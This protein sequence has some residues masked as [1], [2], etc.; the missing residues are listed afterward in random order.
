MTQQSQTIRNV[1]V[2][3]GAKSGDGPE[4]AATAKAFGLALAESGRTL[5]FGGGQVGMMGHVANAA[6]AA[7]GDVIG[8]IPQ[9][10]ATAELLHTGVTKMHVVGGMHERKALMDQLAD[11]IVALP[12]GYGT[13]DE[14]FE[15]ITWSQLGVHRKP[16]ALLN[17]RGFFDPLVAMIDHSVEEGFISPGH[18][19][20]FFVASSVEDVLQGLEVRGK[21]KG[22]RV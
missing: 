21:G 1:C 11:A 22:K 4:Y 20:L 12:G 10:L 7:G 6:L 15:S 5:I 13:L 19:K 16:I 17:T 2:F 14:L 3:C 18:R 9:S 8:V